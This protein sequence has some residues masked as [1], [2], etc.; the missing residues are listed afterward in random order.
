MSENYEVQ[1]AVRVSLACANYHNGIIVSHPTGVSFSNQAGGLCCAQPSVEG[2]YVPFEHNHDFESL[3]DV[4]CDAFESNRAPERLDE[5]DRAI[6][7]LKLKVDRERASELMEAWVPVVILDGSE[8]DWDWKE[9]NG[10][11]YCGTSKMA[12]RKATLIY[13]NCD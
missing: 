13:D 6:A 1:T 7:Y 12:G 4:L 9:S 8:W 11:R 5:I 2:F 10:G 3:H